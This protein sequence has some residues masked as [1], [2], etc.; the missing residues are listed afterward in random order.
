MQHTVPA[1]GLRAHCSRQLDHRDE[2]RGF[3]RTSL[4]ITVNWLH[5]GK[6]ELA[7]ST[8]VLQLDQ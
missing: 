4:V 6:G 5:V 7:S 2:A 8:L 3:L 1:A